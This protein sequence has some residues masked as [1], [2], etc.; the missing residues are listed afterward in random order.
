M[1]KKTI[2]FV[3]Y[4]CP[5]PYDS[6]TPQ[7]GG[8]GGTESTVTRIA[9]GLSEHYNVVVEQHSRDEV[10]THKATYAPVGF[11]EN[12]AHVIALRDPRIMLG[13]HEAHPK[14]KIHLYSHD[15]PSRPIGELYSGGAFKDCTYHI[16]VSNWH[17]AVTMD[18]LKPLGYKGEFKHRVIY[19]PLPQYLPQRAD[20]YDK[21]KLVWLSSPHKGLDRA[22]H[23]LK[24]LLPHN[25]DFKLYVSNPGYYG[26]DMQLNDSLKN[27]VILAGSLPHEEVLNHVKDALCLFYPN[28]VFPETFGMVMSE[29]NAMGIP[30]L[31][32]N[33]G[34]SYEVLDSHPDQ[35]MDCRNDEEVVKRVLKWYHGER[36][37]VRGRPEFKLSRVINEWVRLLDVC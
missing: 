23:L 20:S 1:S 25:P 32:H 30:V 29:A 15:I 33:F 24:L 22:L 18:L 6:L 27:S 16:C 37:N 8:L 36:P 26:L 10:V 19:N 7:Q 9:E 12:P 3:D 35:I 17:K 11:T 13:A 2:C 34:A 5:K 31:T 28:T 21:N 4:T 14:A